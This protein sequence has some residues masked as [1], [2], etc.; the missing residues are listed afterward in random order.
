MPPDRSHRARGAT[1]AR[2]GRARDADGG[3]TLDE[4]VDLVLP[5]L[6]DGLI[7]EKSVSRLRTATAGIPAEL[8]AR[9]GLE[10]SL[11]S[12]IAGADALFCADSETGG[13]Q[14]LA[15]RHPLVNLPPA[16]ATAESWAPVVRLCSRREPGFLLHRATR[17]VW[18][19]LAERDAPSFSFG[20]RMG[21]LPEATRRPLEVLIRALGVGFDALRDTPLEPPTLTSM[22]ALV[23]RLPAGTQVDRGGLLA[24]LPDDVRL[25]LSRIAS[26][27]FVDLVEVSRDRS[28]ARALHGVLDDI[29]QPAGSVR[30][31]IDVHEGVG[32]SIGLICGVDPTGS[33][34]QVAARWGPLLDRLVDAGLCTSERRKALLSCHGLLRERQAGHWPEHLARLSELF[35]DGAESVLRWRVHH[36]TVECDRGQPIHATAHVVAAHDWSTTRAR[37]DS[38][39]R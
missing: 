22:R 28:E 11:G 4:L 8:V 24:G 20:M 35:D 14:M 39:R 18:V 38:S 25:W 37:P 7:G 29:V 21:G 36:V 23:R 17:D 9:F 15:G 3:S 16:L 30:A 32:R 6:P 2:G 1:Q 34:R 27:E 12:E 33:A 10:C 31:R 13:M 5:R 19:D 26:S